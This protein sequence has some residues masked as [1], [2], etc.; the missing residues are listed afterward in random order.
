MSKLSRKLRKLRRLGKEITEEKVIAT[1]PAPLNSPSQNSSTT[2][3]RLNVFGEELSTKG[4]V[5]TTAVE[6]NKFSN[7]HYDYDDYYSDYYYNSGPS[8]SGYG[9]GYGYGSYGG[10]YYGLSE[11]KWKTK[12]GT[13]GSLLSSVYTSYADNLKTERDILNKGIQKVK[14]LITIFNIPKRVYIRVTQ[15]NHF[16]G[17][18]R[19]ILEGVSLGNAEG[20]SEI[21]LYLETKI[22]DEEERSTE[23]KINIITAQ[24][25]H[26]C[27]HIL[28]TYGRTLGDFRANLSIILN[29]FYNSDDVSRS[30][31]PKVLKYIQVLTRSYNPDS[32]VYACNYS[33]P[34]LLN[35]TES[36]KAAGKCVIKPDEELNEDIEVE[37][38]AGD[39]ITK[40]SIIFKIIYL[41]TSLIEDERV[42][43]R[44]MMDRPGVRDHIA[45]LNEYRRAQIEELNLFDHEPGGNQALN[46]IIK[47][48]SGGVP[49]TEYDFINVI[50]SMIYPTKS[51]FDSCRLAVRIYKKFEEFIIS[52][53]GGPVLTEI[54]NT[55]LGNEAINRLEGL[56]ATVPS[57][58]YENYKG[59][60]GEYEGDSEL[61]LNTF[62]YH[63]DENG[64]DELIHNKE[65]RRSKS[66]NSRAIELIQGELND[67][68]EEVSENDVCD[69]RVFYYK[70]QD[71]SDKYKSGKMKE[72][73]VEVSNYSNV[74]KKTILGKF[75]NDKFLIYGCKSGKLNPAQL[76]EAYQG[77]KH[78]YTQPASFETPKVVLTLLI[79]ESG[80]MGGWDSCFVRLVKKAAALLISA[81]GNS[82]NIDLYIYGHSADI[83]HDGDTDIF[84]Y[85]E[86]SKKGSKTI[87]DIEKISYVQGR[88]ENRDGNAIYSVAKRVNSLAF[89]KNAGDKKSIMIV[90]SDGEPS[91]V[92]YRDWEAV[93][94]TREKVIKTQQEFG[95][96]IV[97][98]TVTSVEESEEMFDT[99]VKLENDLS[100]FV[101][102]ISR[103]IANLLESKIETKIKRF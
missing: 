9:Y 98:C 85:K 28:Y 96:Q 25:V 75:K 80:S 20:N 87:T 100:N 76:V 90:L 24:G 30:V 16:K 101:Q 63:Y 2:M 61:E 92:D 65:Q 17:K 32:G 3:P 7:Y 66:I 58:D 99:V 22:L 47:L 43:N 83:Y 6:D 26:E 79:D 54:V 13:G 35:I 93:E 41:F 97:Q 72:L 39:S 62:N 53:Y 38:E 15:D 77:V 103:V 91:A 102:N 67:V 69:G 59:G 52:R 23:D 8:Y 18:R 56:F 44:L 14:E 74:L 51:T 1:T 21:T 34:T 95:T 82:D 78:V 37:V 68:I 71:T 42:N 5:T 31:D 50:K 84:V 49:E 88:R 57:L 94:D 19:D 11:N 29:K 81:F 73:S 55:E 36:K 4:T 48:L 86:G 10:A 12:W 46:D 33:T 60:G 27:A 45:L 89:K 64:K 40:L 70:I